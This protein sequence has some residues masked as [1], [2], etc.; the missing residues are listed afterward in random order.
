M[1]QR[2]SLRTSKQNFASPEIISSHGTFLDSLRSNSTHASQDR[3]TGTQPI[4]PTQGRLCN[5]P[6][7]VLCT[8]VEMVERTPNG[9]ATGELSF[10]LPFVS[11]EIEVCKHERIINCFNSKFVGFF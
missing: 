11:P 5:L 9:P 1:K 3:E 8:A 4:T 7:T 2:H 6:L 10:S